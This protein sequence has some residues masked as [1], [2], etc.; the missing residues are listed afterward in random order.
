VSSALL[1]TAASLRAQLAAFQPG[2]LT[3]R[4]CARVADELAATEKAC[5]AVRLLAAARAIHCRAHESRGFDDGAAWVARQGGVTAGQARQALEAV[6]GLKDCPGTKAALLAGELSWSEASEIAR[7][8]SEVPGAED[9]LLEAA[10]HSSLTVLRD[11]AREH[12]MSNTPIEGLHRVIPVQIARGLAKDAF[13]KAVL[14]DGVAVHTIKHFGRYLP[15][16]FAPR[17]TL[18]LSPGSLAQNA[19]I[20]GGASAWSTTT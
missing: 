12:R 8:Q 18:A 14:H 7:T 17:W 20:A 4:D 1:S 5:A 6:A 13:V 15:A 19:P 11:R 3:G 10:R 2:E 9:V 16:S